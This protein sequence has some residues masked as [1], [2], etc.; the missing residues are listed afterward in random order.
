MGTVVLVLGAQ[1]AQHATQIIKDSKSV[2][3]TAAPYKFYGK[4]YLGSQFSERNRMNLEK[5]VTT[6][7]A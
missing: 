1:D 5:R 6:T 4:F 7:T 2:Q 3:P